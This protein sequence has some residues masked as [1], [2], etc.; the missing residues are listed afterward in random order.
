MF[1]VEL[2]SDSNSGC[3]NELAA[4]LVRLHFYGFLEA[5]IPYFPSSCEERLRR[6]CGTES[7]ELRQ[8]VMMSVAARL[9][10]WLRSFGMTMLDFERTTS[11]IMPFNRNHKC[12]VQI[13]AQLE[14]SQTHSR[15]ALL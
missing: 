12:P 7:R 1:C 5:I 11:K 2:K 15:E 3:H 9:G 8:Q 6:I 10:S 13:I 4:R 14:G